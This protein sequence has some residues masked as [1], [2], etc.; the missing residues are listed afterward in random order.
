MSLALLAPS[1]AAAREITS[2]AVGG[3]G[4]GTTVCTRVQSLTAKGDYRAGETGASNVSA[5][6]TVKPCDKTE[7][8]AVETTVREWSSNTFVY[9]SPSAVL[10]GSFTV[11]GRFYGLYTV[12][13]I[14]TDATTGAVLETKSTTVSV[15]PKGV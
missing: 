7:L 9:D 10:S 12:S 13:V 1:L 6:Y 2:G 5:S 14:V 11:Y 3:G 8:L 4:G 15:V